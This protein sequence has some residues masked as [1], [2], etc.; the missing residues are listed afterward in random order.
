MTM[1]A[2]QYANKQAV[3]WG[4]AHSDIIWNYKR[5]A[6]QQITMPHYDDE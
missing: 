2:W 1:K 6:V 3:N 4:N 5:K